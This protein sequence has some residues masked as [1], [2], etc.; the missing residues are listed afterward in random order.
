MKRLLLALVLCAAAL[1]VLSSALYT[2]NETEQALVV[3]LGRPIGVE[4]EPGLKIKFPFIDTV[5]TYDSRRLMLESTPEQVILG[6]QKRVEVSTYTL[7]KITDPLRF[8]QSVRTTNA[9]ESQ[10]RQIV[11]SSLRRE[12]GRVMLATL[13]S[14]DRERLTKVIC[15]DV[16]EEA[17]PL[18]IEIVDV[19]IR[20]ADL[21]AET[22]Q[23]IYSRMTSE[24]QRE[25]MELRAQ[26][27]EWAQQIKSKAER[28]RT[29]ILAEAER[30]SRIT[31]GEGDA[32]VS[33]MFAEAFG[34]DPKFFELY[35]ALQ[36]YRHALAE[37]SP[38][39]VLSPSAKFLRY[40][41]AGPTVAAPK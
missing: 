40:L 9:A 6:D 10:V 1:V 31:R 23:A 20:R 19:R 27:F 14:A 2:V 32:E 26:G 8:Y 7:F 11:G 34:E 21:P 17:R 38:T 37:S 5:I 41:D 24:R 33:R 28:E 15:A 13:L 35:R 36:T 12:L 39:L 30:Q 18:G 3:R 25:A 16:S 22:S 4:T 29:V